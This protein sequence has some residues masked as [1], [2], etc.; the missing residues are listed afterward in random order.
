MVW[1]LLR[2]LGPDFDESAYLK[3]IGK[4]LP[5]SLSAQHPISDTAEV[6]QSNAVDDAELDAVEMIFVVGCGH[7][8]TTL[9]ATILG[10]SDAIHTIKRET[11]WFLHGQDF[12][13]E[14]RQER[15][16]AIAAGKRCLLEKTPRHVYRYAEITAAFPNAKFVIMT[17]EPKDV[18]ASIKNRSGNF[19]AALQRWL[20]DNQQALRIAE[21]PN[22]ILV[23]Y[24]DLVAQPHETLKHICGFLGVNYSSDSLLDYHRSKPRWFGVKPKQTDGKGEQGHLQNR[25]WQMTQPIHD[26]RGIWKEHLTEQEAQQ[27]DEA[28]AGLAEQLGYTGALKSS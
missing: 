4:P 21:H 1:R 15:E 9:M 5:L 2:R 10:E 20:R 17:R 28:T 12:S 27:V 3:Q 13:T 16:Q 11:E 18:V 7:T 6:H 26:R 8:W 14:L 22:A 25:A 23:R 19:D 24:E